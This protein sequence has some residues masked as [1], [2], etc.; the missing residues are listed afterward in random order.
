M[1]D[2]AQFASKDLEVLVRTALIHG[3]LSPGGAMAVE[4]YR[5]KSNLTAIEQRQ[6][7]ILDSAIADGCIVP[8]Q[9]HA[10]T[11]S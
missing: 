10:T 1:F 5:T 6:L 2:T 7:R 11:I 3:E 4:Y 8:I 9:I